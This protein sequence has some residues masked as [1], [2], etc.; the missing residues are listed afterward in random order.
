MHR[1][2]TK[3]ISIE[4]DQGNYEVSFNP[5]V[6]RGYLELKEVVEKHITDFEFCR[7]M[8]ASDKKNAAVY[9]ISKQVENAEKFI[10]AIHIAIGDQEYAKVEWLL[11]NISIDSLSEIAAAI[12]NK[13]T[14]Y[15]QEKLKEGFEV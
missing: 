11:Q 4:T 15:Y 2:F 13:Y 14:E 12:M 10:S 6:P 9:W 7:I 8:A 1:T 3:T 5:S